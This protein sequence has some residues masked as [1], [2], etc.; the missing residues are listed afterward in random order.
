MVLIYLS[1]EKI[2]ITPS[3]ML[4]PKMRKKSMRTSMNLF[5]WDI[6]GQESGEN[7]YDDRDDADNV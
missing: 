1:S 5:F 6:E 3:L 7:E 2:E 4:F